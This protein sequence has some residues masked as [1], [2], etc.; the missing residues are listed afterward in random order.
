MTVVSHRGEARTSGPHPRRTQR[1]T[2]RRTRRVIAVAL[3]VV[4]LTLLGNVAWQ[5]WGTNWVSHRKHDRIVAAVVEAW[6]Q[7]KGS[8]AVEVDEGK[9][10]ALVRVPRFGDAYVI[11]VLEGTSDTVLAAGYGHF[12]DTAEPGGVG[13]YALAAHRVTHGEPLRRMP[14]LQPGDEIVI[15]TRTRIFT[16]VLDTGG[17]DLVVDFTANWVIEALPKN[18][19]AGG[20]QPE[21]L[22]GQRLI[23]LTTCASLF[24]TDN[25]L[26]AFGHLETVSWKR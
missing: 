22:Q 20:S 7:G 26:V 16:Y 25:R 3:I 21:Q 12:E 18:P 10:F 9:A 19:D 13:N 2:Q 5:F 24:H 14:E 6:E 23:T 17:D 8:G 15:E 1:R 4:G 11:P